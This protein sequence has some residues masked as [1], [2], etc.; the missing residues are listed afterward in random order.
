[1]QEPVKVSALPTV[2]AMNRTSNVA[3]RRLRILRV[4]LIMSEVLI[5][6]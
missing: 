6:H 5:R 4:P 2:A 1:M 3:V